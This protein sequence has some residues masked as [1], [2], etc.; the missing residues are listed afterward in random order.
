LAPFRAWHIF[1]GE[2]EEI[3][4]RSSVTVVVLK[5]ENQTED[6]Q[7]ERGRIVTQDLY[8]ILQLGVKL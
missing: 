2:S 6:P 1:I 7:H 4:A 8:W 3:D 5:A